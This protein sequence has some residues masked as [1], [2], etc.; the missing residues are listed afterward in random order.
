MALLKGKQSEIPTDAI[1]LT[2]QQALEYELKILKNWKHKSD[3]FWFRYGSAILVSSTVLSGMYINNYYR[4]K[5][6]LLYYGRA[7]SYLPICVIPGALSFLLHTE[8]V[9]KDLVLQKQVC[10]VCLEL[11]SS[12]LQSLTGFVFPFLAAPV[13]NLMLANKYGTANLPSL[14]KEPLEILKFVKAKVKPIQ[15][16]LFA[17]FVG[18]ALIASGVTYLEANSVFKVNGKLS[19]LEYDLEHQ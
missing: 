7:S 12:A 14:A 16:I 5:F 4:Y 3:T 9:L 2:E 11:R 17:I 18:Q 13:T 1:I 6:K 15:N 8:L 10:P 19:K